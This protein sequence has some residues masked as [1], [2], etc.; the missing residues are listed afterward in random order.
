MNIETALKSNKKY[1]L[2]ILLKKPISNLI[3]NNS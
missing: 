1:C 3:G 2:D